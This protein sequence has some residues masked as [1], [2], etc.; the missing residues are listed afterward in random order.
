MINPPPRSLSGLGSETA[1]PTLLSYP[2]P[3]TTFIATSTTVFQHKLFADQKSYG[4]TILKFVNNE[5]R[6]FYSEGKEK[7]SIY[8]QKCIHSN[9]TYF[10]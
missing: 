2:L 9:G 7:I 5:K 8:R 1:V 4:N 10:V 6:K 3:I